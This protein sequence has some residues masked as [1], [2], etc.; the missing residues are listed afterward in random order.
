MIGGYRIKDK[1]GSIP[2]EYLNAESIEVDK[3]IQRLLA[4]AM[5]EFAVGLGAGGDDLASD[6]EEGSGSGSDEE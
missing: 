5:A 4:I 3:S 2:A 1:K 6:G